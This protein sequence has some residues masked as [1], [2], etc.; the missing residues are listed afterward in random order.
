MTHKHS[1]EFTDGRGWEG[2]CS[3][4][5]GE[6]RAELVATGSTS[7]RWWKRLRLVWVAA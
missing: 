1:I 5:G 4:C 2:R 7:V 6:F 3:V